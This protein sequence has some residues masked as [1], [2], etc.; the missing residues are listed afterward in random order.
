MVTTVEKPK[1][2]PINIQISPAGPI[3]NLTI[4]Q[5]W[6]L[7]KELEEALDEVIQKR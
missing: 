1:N 6:K 7:K 4:G 5:A 2:R 3:Y